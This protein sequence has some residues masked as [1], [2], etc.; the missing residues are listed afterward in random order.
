MY[1]F[2][3]QLWKFW[4]KIWKIF[5]DARMKFLFYLLL[6]KIS[7]QTLGCS[8]E[9]SFCLWTEFGAF[10]PKMVHRIR[11][12]RRK[13]YINNKYWSLCAGLSHGHT[14]HVRFLTAVKYKSKK[15]ESTSRRSSKVLE[16]KPDL[17][18]ANKMLVISGGDGYEDFRSSS[19]SEIAGREDSTNHLLIWRF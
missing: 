13:F 5:R 8:Y 17:N 9:I 16:R 15:K 3:E 1:K 19:V 7:T 12:R 4:V 10:S 2:W 18:D 11:P 6:K 14:G